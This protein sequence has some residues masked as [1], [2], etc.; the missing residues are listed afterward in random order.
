M[1]LNAALRER[2]ES[3]RSKFLTGMVESVLNRYDNT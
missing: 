2:E 1:L 3:G